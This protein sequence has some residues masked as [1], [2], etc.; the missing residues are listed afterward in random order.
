MVI[1]GVLRRCLALSVIAGALGFAA[2]A[3][4][5]TIG[6]STTPSP[7]VGGQ[8]FTV[9]VSGSNDGPPG[10]NI[11]VYANLY[12]AP[13]SCDPAAA[14]TGGFIAT[15]VSGIVSYSVSGQT[16][17]LHGT[18]VVCAW[19]SDDSTPSVLK[20][21]S[22]SVTVSDPTSISLSVSPS[23][24]YQGRYTLITASGN[25]DEGIDAY[26]TSKPD[27]SG[28]GCAP[29]P[30]QDGGTALN[31]DFDYSAG[32][33]SDGGYSTA[34]LP[35]GTTLLCGW[36]MA[37][38]AASNDPSQVLATTSTQLTVLTPHYSL[39]LSGPTTVGYF[40]AGTVVASWHGDA[41]ANLIVTAISA[42]AHSCPANR[43]KAG[44]T[45]AADLVSVDDGEGGKQPWAGVG[46]YLPTDPVSGTLRMRFP[47]AYGLSAGTYL[48]C[49]WLQAQPSGD[50]SP[51]GTAVLSGPVS[52]KIVVRPPVTYTGR[53]SEGQKTG[54]TLNGRTI[55]G[56][57]LYPH[58]RC[59]GVTFPQYNLLNF[60]NFRAKK[61]GAFSFVGGSSYESTRV[62]VYGHIHRRY[63]SGWFTASWRENAQISCNTGRITFFFR[64]HGG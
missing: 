7:P 12:P 51:A 25:S 40:Q 35:A 44:F 45:H 42:R 30:G 53:D 13:Y 46:A 36:V 2:P 4:A 19:L 57:S 29:T 22:L 63:A 23:P 62:R 14:D 43:A 61:N 39:S 15:S 64:R 26:V 16:T 56:L 11:N 37:T 9:T 54:F 48:V 20:F 21:A 28:A 5:A 50:S 33:W 18:Y 41:P 27:T 3:Q 31:Q 49:G 58:A 6:I 47:P 55:I 59:T 52:L 17:Q 8:A 32:P 1:P 10:D 34:S 60:P 38:G 24:T